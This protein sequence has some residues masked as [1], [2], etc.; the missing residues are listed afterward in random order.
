VAWYVLPL[1]TC[2]VFMLM[3]NTDMVATE[4]RKIDARKKAAKE[5]E[6]KNGHA[7]GSS[8]S[9]S[10]SKGKSGKSEKPDA[11]EHEGKQK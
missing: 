9:E 2:W 4:E 3:F 6:T 1:A 7:S 10:S 5:E 11:A 8:N